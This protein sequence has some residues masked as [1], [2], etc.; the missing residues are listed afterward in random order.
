MVDAG[1]RV[2][3]SHTR[4]TLS[5]LSREAPSDA[6]A[7]LSVLRP[8]VR[9]GLSAAVP[10]GWIPAAWDVAVACALRGAVGQAGAQRIA[11]L[12]M[13]ENMT[14]TLLGGLASAALHLFGTSPGALYGWAGRAWSHLCRDFGEM[15]LESRREGE[16]V[17]VLSGLPGEAVVPE[18]LDV[19]AAGLEAILDVCKVRGEV[20]ADRVPGGGRFV[21]RW[22]AA[23]GR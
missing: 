23:R 11:R 20:R 8:E 14:G 2:R 6:R 19:I 15:R 4:L 5:V 7:V 12:A 3:A 16:A 9:E 17:V 22:A 13:V 10:A 1:P 18:Y 21:A